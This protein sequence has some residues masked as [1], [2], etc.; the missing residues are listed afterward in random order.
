MEKDVL[1]MIIFIYI[2]VRGLDPKLK[3]RRPR[4]KAQSQEF[5]AQNPRPKTQDPF[6]SGECALAEQHYSS[7]FKP[8]NALSPV[9]QVPGV[10]KGMILRR[11]AK[12][13]KGIIVCQG[14]GGADRTKLACHKRMC[15]RDKGVEGTRH[16]YHNGIAEG[17]RGRQSHF[18][19]A[20]KIAKG[21]EN[22]ERSQKA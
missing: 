9:P 18:H 2:C 6:L 1:I 3:R 14:A 5:K 11:R 7:S 20:R 19:V 12:V 15:R 21:Y 16:A 4:T 17:K 13:P 8:Y 22:L 10:S